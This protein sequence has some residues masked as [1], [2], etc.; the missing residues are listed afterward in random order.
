MFSEHVTFLYSS[1]K[2]QQKFSN[3]S[4]GTTR[5]VSFPTSNLFLSQT[6]HNLDSAFYLNTVFELEFVVVVVVVLTKNY[7]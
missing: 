3:V 4:T 5:I 1:S 2:F 6:A 7:S